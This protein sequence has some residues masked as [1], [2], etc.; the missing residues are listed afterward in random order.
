LECYY[1]GGR[2]IN[3]PFGETSSLPKRFN[4]MGKRDAILRSQVTRGTWDHV[5][6]HGA[7]GTPRDKVAF[8]SREPG[9]ASRP[10]FCP[11][12]RPPGQCLFTSST[13]RL[14]PLEKDA[15]QPPGRIIDL[16]PNACDCSGR[17]YFRPPDP[18]SGRGRGHLFL[19]RDGRP[20]LHAVGTA[21]PCPPSPAFVA[22]FRPHMA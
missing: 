21:D 10:P 19:G 6:F 20:P 12:I 22:F 9:T 7:C 14:S 1:A 5:S 8:Q 2:P 18:P 17:R 16:T 13:T 15:D 3:R 11:M 4:L